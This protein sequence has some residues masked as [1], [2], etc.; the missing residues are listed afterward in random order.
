MTIKYRSTSEIKAEMAKITQA[1]VNILAKIEQLKREEAELKDL[2]GEDILLGK[3]TESSARLEKV[4]RDLVAHNLAIAPADLNL[5][6]L[7]SELSNAKAQEGIV[8]WKQLLAEMGKQVAEIE[9][10]SVSLIDQATQFR[11]FLIAN[12]PEVAALG[13]DPS[14]I[15]EKL[16]FLVH[17]QLEAETLQL[18]EI[19]RVKEIHMK[20][21]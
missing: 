20:A 7:E 12:R 8:R 16:L 2:V 21:E 4:Q 1:K 11:A 6:A 14:Y 3:S 17:A 15:L 18:K 9:S 13:A 19:R 5:M 10:L